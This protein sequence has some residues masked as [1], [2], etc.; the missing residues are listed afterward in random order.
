[1]ETWYSVAEMK[2]YEELMDFG[3]Y[4]FSHAHGPTDFPALL[5][6][7]YKREY[8]MEGIHYIAREDGRIRAAVG[9][10]PLKLKILGESLPGRGIGMVSVHPYARSRGYMRTLM[11][12][13]LADMRRDGIVFSCL[14]G[15]RQRYEYFGYTP[16][17]TRIS[18]ECRRTNIRHFLGS[19]FSP[20]FSLRPLKEGDA[21]LEDIHRIHRSK[22]AHFERD[23]GKFFDILSSWKNR[24][25]ALLEGTL[26]AGYIVYNDAENTV[27]EINLSDP[28]RT[29]E[30]LACFLNY[31]GGKD[32]VSVIVQPWETAKLGA[33]AAFAEDYHISTAYS[34]AVFD[35]R[36]FLSALLKLKSASGGQ[37]SGCILPEGEAAFRI[38]GGNGGPKESCFRVTVRDGEARINADSGEGAVVLDPLQAIR[39]FFSPLSPWTPPLPHRNPLLRGIL[40]LP[41]FF[42]SPDG[43]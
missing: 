43:V 33:F 7:L 10:Y 24:V 15:Q 39:F 31:A 36:S 9:A 19:D 14:G 22:A 2:D 5:P 28:G 40:P 3:N 16:A 34:F 42:E 23:R 37:G 11:D 13:A 21:E 30:A 41:L 12:M 1:M 27:A 20:V 26:F 4:V 32:R 29:A 6:K 35:W 25:F 8:F 17:G 38:G 18:F